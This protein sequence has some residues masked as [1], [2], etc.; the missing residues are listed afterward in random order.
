NTDADDSTLSRAA[1]AGVLLAHLR[2]GDRVAKLQAIDRVHS[3][4]DAA[5]RREVT[6]VVRLRRAAERV[7]GA[8]RVESGRRPGQI[9]A[10]EAAAIHLVTQRDRVLDAV[11]LRNEIRHH[12]AELGADDV[13]RLD[14]V[15]EVLDAKRRV[16]GIQLEL[17]LSFGRR[18]DRARLGRAVVI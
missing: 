5:K 17:D 13:A 6:F 14:L 10:R 16:A 15:H 11:L 4:Y 2:R 12:P 1:R 18:P 9:A 8:A 3:S 7:T